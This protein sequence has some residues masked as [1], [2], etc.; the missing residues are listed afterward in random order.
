MVV[1]REGN[2]NPLQ[3]SCLENPMDRG[4]WWAAV[5]GVS[6]SQT[7]LS[8]FTL[9]FH[10]PALEKEMATHSSALAW[11]IPGTAEPGGLLS[12]GSH[13]VAHNGCNS[14]SSSSMVVLF[15]IFWASS[16]LFSVVA[17]AV[18]IP[19]YSAWL[20]PFF[21]HPCQCLL[22]L[23]FCLFLFWGGLLIIPF[24][25]LQGDI[26]LWFLFAFPWQLQM[27]SVFSWVCKLPVCI[28]WKMSV[29]IFCPFLDQVVCFFG[30]E[31]CE[32]FI[33]TGYWPL[34]RY[35]ICRYHL[36]FSRLPLHFVDGF[37][38]CTQDVLA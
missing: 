32:F 3:Y 2:G 21:P 38:Y 20:F 36:P 1:L 10:F 12:M 30:V 18:H 29:D 37:F 6:K 23:V 34:I 28:P 15:L 31:L 11:R 19:T 26:S 33:Y 9:T 17:A 5:H 14:S 13:R 4:A 22:G 24:W 27:L 8:N 7:W 16:I 35:I 25:Q